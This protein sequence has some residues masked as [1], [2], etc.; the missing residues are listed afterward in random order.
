[1]KVEEVGQVYVEGR[2]IN[3]DKVSSEDILVKLYQKALSEE[4][5]LLKKIN[6]IAGIK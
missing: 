5:E 4:D 1:M 2:A 3:T 6:R